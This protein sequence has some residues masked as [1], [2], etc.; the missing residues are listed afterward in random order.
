MLCNLYYG[1]VENREFGSPEQVFYPIEPVGGCD[2]LSAISKEGKT[3][4]V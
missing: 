3:S 2:V 1:F 4:L